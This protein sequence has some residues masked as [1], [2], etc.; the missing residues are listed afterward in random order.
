MLFD[1]ANIKQH[2]VLYLAGLYYLLCYIFCI[3][4]FCYIAQ[5][6]W[7]DCFVKH[8]LIT[9]LHNVFCLVFFSNCINYNIIIYN[10]GL[11]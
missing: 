7:K 5:Y 8:D 10:Y 2:Q 6:A 3:A 9:V 11:G 1:T 4:Y